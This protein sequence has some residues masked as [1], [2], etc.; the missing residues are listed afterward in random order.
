MKG[1]HEPAVNLRRSMQTTR[2]DDGS[3]ML[4]A[5]AVSLA[6]DLTFAAA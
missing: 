4:T 5:C 3:K 6:A 2:P 1:R